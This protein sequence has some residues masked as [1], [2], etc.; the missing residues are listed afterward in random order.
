MAIST[1]ASLGVLQRVLPELAPLSIVTLHQ[2]Q[3]GVMPTADQVS[4]GLNRFQF[5]LNPS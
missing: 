3:D 1:G 2:R 4:Q 5:A